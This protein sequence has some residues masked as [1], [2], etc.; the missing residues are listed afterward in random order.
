MLHTVLS[1]S[2]I[3]FPGS[4]FLILPLSLTFLDTL[5]YLLQLKVGRYLQ[6]VSYV[7]VFAQW[8]V[9]TE[10]RSVKSKML[11]HVW[12][13]TFW[14]HCYY[15]WNFQTENAI[16]IFG[17]YAICVRWMLW[18]FSSCF[19][20]FLNYAIHLALRGG[21]SHAGFSIHSYFLLLGKVLR[22]SLSKVITNCEIKS[23][24]ICLQTW[25]FQ[26]Y[27]TMNTVPH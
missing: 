12:R 14:K 9:K 5:R 10:A 1:V 22:S 18:K 17:C 21:D 7:I 26:K 24:L 25:L 3:L 8:N 15:L 11:Q 19:L 4:C 23:L 27:D 6:M 20:T 2:S 13:C 16:N